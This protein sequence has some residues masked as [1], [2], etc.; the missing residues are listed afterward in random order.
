MKRN[1]KIYVLLSIFLATM[2]LAMIIVACAEK[3]P[4]I[5]PD[6]IKPIVVTEFTAHDT[7]DP[8]IWL[9][10]LNPAQSLILGTDKDADGALYVFDLQGKIIEEKTVRNLQRPNNVDIEC[11]LVLNGVPTDIAVTTE[12][13]TNKLRI[14]SL[15]DMKQADNGGIEVFENQTQRAPM[16][17]SLYKR[18]ADG[19]IY[20][21]VSRKKGPTDGTYLWQYLLED[22]GS[23]N[24]KATKVREFG[25][26]S[27]KKEIEAIAVDDELGYVYYSDE[28]VGVRKYL[29]DPDAENANQEL[30]L[31]ATEGF[32]ADNEG[33]SIYKINDGTGYILVSDQ[34]ANLFRVF[35]REGEPG[36]P[37]NHQLVKVVPAAT[38]GSDGSEVTN[39]VLNDS[40][41]V[42]LFVAMSDNR[43]FQFYSW[44]DIAGKNLVIAP[45]GIR[46]T[47]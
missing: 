34:G 25:T 36:A 23:G 4:A 10:P 7:D 8:A 12:R 27:G 44:A 26:W 33:I 29:A 41:P 38:S 1:N 22:D 46:P 24:I 6:A 30:A 13:F 40:F 28:T 19:A 21:I 45:N 5:S 43:T 37:H 3:K 42:G 17:I 9:N 35:K 14:F 20:A 16:G 11:G 32:A 47:E 18:P 15:P 2:V 31:F 39:A